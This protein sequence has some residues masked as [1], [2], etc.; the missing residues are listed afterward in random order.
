MMEAAEL[1]GRE[2]FFMCFWFHENSKAWA[3]GIENSRTEM[4]SPVSKPDL[5]WAGHTPFT[6]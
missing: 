6:V 3:Y 2:E 1:R 4:G 5:S